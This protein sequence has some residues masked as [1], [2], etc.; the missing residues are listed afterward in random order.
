MSFS[1]FVFQCL[2]GL[3]SCWIVAGNSYTVAS[4]MF[5]RL[6]SDLMALFANV[7]GVRSTDSVFLMCAVT[8][9]AVGAGSVLRCRR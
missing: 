1:L 9:V 2:S 7:P 3:V 8:S 4:V 5:S 6:V